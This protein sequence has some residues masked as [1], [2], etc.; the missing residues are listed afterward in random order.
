MVFNKKKNVKRERSLNGALNVYYLVK[1]HSTA[2]C[3]TIHHIRWFDNWNSIEIQS[4]Q[5]YI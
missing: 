3:A 2:H 5:I 4:N 1:Q